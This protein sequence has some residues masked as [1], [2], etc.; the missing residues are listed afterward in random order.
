MK[1][2]RND[3]QAIL[4]T[5][6]EYLKNPFL[7]IR[8]IPDWDWQTLVFVQLIVSLASGIIAGLVDR[9]IYS[10]FQGLLLTPFVALITAI[11]ST[12]FLYYA[13][14][15]LTQQ[16]LAP[17]PLFT[18]IILA[19]IPFFIFQT[20]SGIFPPIT[21]VGFLLAAMITVI[22]IVENFKIEKRLVLKVVGSLVVVFVLIWLGEKISLYLDGVR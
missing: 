12:I 2:T 6:A 19:N 20:I 14:Y 5:L 1:L 8:Q 13:F 15:L 18:V 7:K 17:R 3:I 11:V 21:L 4:Q 22:G 10:F 16:L 9:N